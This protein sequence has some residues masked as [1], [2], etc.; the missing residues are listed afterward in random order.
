M[1]TSQGRVHQ[2]RAVGFRLEQ[3][4][5]QIGIGNALAGYAG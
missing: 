1:S 4:P 5:I 2:N 3:H